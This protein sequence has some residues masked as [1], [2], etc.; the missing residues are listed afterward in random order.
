[1]CL[2]RAYLGENGNKEFLMEDVAFLKI[3]GNKLHM[4]TLFGEQKELEATISE[5]DFQN[6]NIILQKSA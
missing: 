4:W 3:D 6:S 1:M 5:I 2:A